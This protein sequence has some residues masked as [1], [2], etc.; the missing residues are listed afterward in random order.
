[1]GDL[2]VDLSVRGDRTTALYRALLEAVR[3]GRLAPGERLPPTR[4][5]A[6]DLGVARTT[7]ATAYDRLVA[8]GYLTTRVGAGTFVAEAARPAPAPRRGTD[9]AP[10]GGWERRPQPTSGGAP[11]PAYDFR[12]GIPDARL[13]PFD[14]W[15]RLV[16]AELRVG[17][18]DLGTYAD[19][20]GHRPLR[21]A[22]ARQVALGRGVT[23]TADEVL[24]TQGTQQA[25]DL[26]TRVLVSPGDVVAVEEPGYPLAREVFE[27]HGA[28]VVPVRVDLEG[29]VVDELP[30]RARL[31]FTTPSH[32]FPTGPPLS[33]SRRRALLAF[34]ARHRCAVVEDD[35]DSEFRY[36]ERPLETLHAM[37]D[38]GRV[39]YLGTF[40]KSLVPGLRA[41]Y[42][43]APA[44]LQDA[45][46]AA[47]QL[48]V[49]YV[50]VPAQAALARFLEDGLFARH[51]RR[52]RAAY[53]ERRAL[54]LEQVHGPLADH[55][56]LVPCQ[57]GLHMT[58]VL[59]D[60]SRD[61]GAV[62]RAAAEEGVAV[63]ALSS[64]AVGGAPRGVVLGYGAA[65]PATIRPGLA[66]LA[67][68]LA[69]AP[70]TAGPRPR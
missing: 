52:A 55:L 5:L 63:E 29:L 31:V 18:H 28:R 38:A 26:V 54:L 35:Y 36:T 47:L 27:A 11:K 56:E 70:S 25:L 49:G 57:A 41:G 37:D 14:T 6:A 68:V 3:G 15:R 13:F 48:S 51:L 24:V 2:V 30:E 65:D 50:D 69:S 62:V 67:G 39:L 58:T 59:R 44:L 1:M 16:T 12:V 32:Q 61:D 42:L 17:A 40:S 10:R 7:V 8:E 43:V 22:I 66:R 33:M 60:Q 46:R 20:A 9:L 45:L 4:A 64:Y 34:A 21:E 23:T 19:P 53:A